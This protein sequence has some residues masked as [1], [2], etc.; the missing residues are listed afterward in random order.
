[1]GEGG[2][3]PDEG[4]F[5]VPIF[6]RHQYRV[7]HRIARREHLSVPHAQHPPA[8]L[9]QKP[10]PRCVV[11]YIGFA[12]MCRTINLNHQLGSATGKIHEIWPDGKLAHEFETI[13]PAI[14]QFFPQAAFGF[15]VI[16]AQST[17]ASPRHF[18]LLGHVG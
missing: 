17:S 10:R 6:Q 1:M 3:R 13:E 14:A 5:L 9:F 12:P 18:G 8:L 11:S 4:S 16:F 2:Q 7:T 15:G